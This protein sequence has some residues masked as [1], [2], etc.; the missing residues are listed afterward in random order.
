MQKTLLLLA[1]LSLP[2]LSPAQ[3]NPTLWTNLNSLHSG[4]KIQIIDTAS[5]KYSGTFINASDASIAFAQTSGQENLQRPDIRTVKL[6]QNKHR[7]RNSL[8]IGAAGAGIGAGIGA[9]LHKGC[10]SQ[11]FC[12]DIGG[13]ALPAGI[14]AVIGGIGAGVGGLAGLAAVLLTSGPEA[15]LPRGSTLDVVLEHELQLEASQINYRDLGQALSPTPPP[16]QQ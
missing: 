9:A 14:G 2:C 12:L 8:I 10:A 11:S 4:Q 5:K 13:R 6:M 7:L 16:A 15:E 1:V 3:A